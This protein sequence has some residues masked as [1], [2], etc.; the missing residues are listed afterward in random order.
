MRVLLSEAKPGEGERLREALRGL[1]G[2]EVVGC[3]QDGL[4]LAQMARRLAPDVALAWSDLPG[5]DGY[6]A[7]QLL[8]QLSPGVACVVIARRGEADARERGMVVGARGVVSEESLDSLP[9]VILP[10]I[11]AKQALPASLVEAVRDAERAPLVIGVTGGKGGVGKTTVAVNVACAIARDRGKKVVV[12]EGPGQMG[13]AALL[14]DLDARHG[15]AELAD[16]A[17]IDESVIGGLVAQHSSGVG[18]LPAVG[19]G[20]VLDPGTVSAVANPALFGRVIATLKRLYDVAIVDLPFSHAEVAAYAAARCHCLAVVA[21]AEDLATLRN[22]ASLLAMLRE[23]GMAEEALV[24]VCNRR[25]RQDPI[26]DD[27]FQRVAG[28]KPAANVPWDDNVIAAGN[29]GVPVVIRSP[30]S[31]AAR[32]LSELAERLLKAARGAAQAG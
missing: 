20:Q 22:T 26:T 17:E 23:R 18:V 31:P 15:L 21:T 4:E 10:I 25:R 27:D 3:A 30:A 14:L 8:G 19:D 28:M 7:C 5:V 32:A 6:A 2:V 13:D 1:D 11:E 9:S 24:L 16:A 12:V 29:E